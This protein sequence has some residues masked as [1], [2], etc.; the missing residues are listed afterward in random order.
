M[1]SYFQNYPCPYGPE[2]DLGQPYPGWGVGPW[3]A[4]PSRLGVGATTTWTIGK[5]H[6]RLPALTPSL[7]WWAWP[8]GAVAVGG[9][10]A[11]ILHKKG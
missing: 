8:V 1:R 5:G 9:L 6:L 4:G 2:G 3:M 11:L 10:L 7:P